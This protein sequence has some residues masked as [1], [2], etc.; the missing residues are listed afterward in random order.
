[1][2][3]AHVIRAIFRRNFVSYF[4]SPTGYVFITVFIVIASVLAFCLPPFFTKNLANLDTLNL[5]FPYLLLFFV[6]AVA[7]ATWSEERKQGTDELLLTLP[8]RD[9]EIVLGKYLSVVGIYTVALLFG[10]TQVIVLIWLGS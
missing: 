9:V 8:A 10:L 5:F 6:P 7:M 2:I 3:R 4:S 1:M